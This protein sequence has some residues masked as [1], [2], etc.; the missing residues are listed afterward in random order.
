M[1]LNFTNFL[2]ATQIIKNLA[3]EFQGFD[4][5]LKNSV[6]LKVGGG[7]QVDKIAA[8]LNDV[9]SATGTFQRSFDIA[10]S[11]GGNILAKVA[12]LNKTID[13]SLTK[14]T[15]ESYYLKAIANTR[16]NNDDAALTNLKN[17]IAKNSSLK[18]KATKDREFLRFATNSTFT[19]LIK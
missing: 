10:S 15:A 18:E 2:S 14:E 16:L 4:K 19:S 3:N 7:F 9:K 12:E 11:G 13:A 17:A 6:L 8:L 5:N 1:T